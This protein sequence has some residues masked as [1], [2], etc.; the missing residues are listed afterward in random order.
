MGMSLQLRKLGYGPVLP[1]M[2]SV[3]AIVA[4]WEFVSTPY[5]SHS[6]TWNGVWLSLLALPL[7]ALVLAKK[8]P[9]TGSRFFVY[10]I[11]GSVLFLWRFLHMDRFSLWL[12]YQAPST[13]VI[14]ISWIGF[15]LG[16]G[17]LCGFFA[18]VHDW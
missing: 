5:V 11:L 17:M 1:G 13:P 18:K 6:N 2:M 15:A 9:G 10:G 16:M 12:Q 4:A 8:H 7:G 14:V 3:Y